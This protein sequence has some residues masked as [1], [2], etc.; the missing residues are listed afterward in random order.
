MPSFLIFGIISPS[1]FIIHERMNPTTFFPT[2]LVHT[3]KN[4]FNIFPRQ[5]EAISVSV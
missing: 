2:R 3:L 1:G 4:L 5:Y